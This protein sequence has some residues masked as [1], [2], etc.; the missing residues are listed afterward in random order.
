[1]ADNEKMTETEENIFQKRLDAIKLLAPEAQQQAILQL[2][3]DYEGIRGR[4]KDE[5]EMAYADSVAAT[6]QGTQAG[7]IYHAASPLSHLSSAL[8]QTW[9]GMERGRIGKRRRELEEMYQKGIGSM[10]EG[11]LTDGPAATNTAVPEVQ[12]G[13]S[14]QPEE[15]VIGMTEMTAGGPMSIQGQPSALSGAL[16]QM[17]PTPPVG[18]PGATPGTPPPPTMP[19]QIPPGMTPGRTT[20]NV[21]PVTGDMMAQGNRQSM[22]M[23]VSPTFPGMPPQTGMSTQGPPV[24][25]SIPPV[26]NAPGNARMPF[27]PPQAPTMQQSMANLLRSGRNLSPDQRQDISR[28]MW[29]FQ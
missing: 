4:L 25:P 13:M 2:S 8:R 22:Q 20:P 1:M 18:Q 16:R 11:G 10:F 9:G 27:V 15:D 12:T 14:M 28:L 23:P 26:P 17:P 5:L 3:Q 19:G 7:G 24:P 21:S 6:P 29:G